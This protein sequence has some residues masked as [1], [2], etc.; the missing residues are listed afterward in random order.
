MKRIVVFGLFIVA[1]CL[2]VGVA[3]GQSRSTSNQGETTNE[4]PLGGCP[5]SSGTPEGEGNCGLPTDTVNG[6]CNFDPNLFSAISCGQ[7]YCG[8]VAAENNLRD[9]DWYELDLPIADNVTAT[10]TIEAPGVLFEVLGVCGGPTLGDNDTGGTCTQ[11][12]INFAGSAGNNY[13]FVATSDFN[14]VP[15][16]AEYTLDVTCETVP[17]ELEKFQVE[18]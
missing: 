2:T 6:G 13:I 1:L 8:T 7:T 16:G 9:T 18:K 12:E 10:A 5:C 15:C 3:E 4:G 17:V 11:L 14:G